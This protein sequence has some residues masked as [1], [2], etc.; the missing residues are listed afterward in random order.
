LKRFY[1][2][3]IRGG[4]SCEGIWRS[5]TI[6]SARRELQEQGMEEINLALLRSD[7]LDFLD[8]E[9]QAGGSAGF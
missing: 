5:E 7:N 4:R 8:L 2:I 6:D 1:Y 3:A 9:A